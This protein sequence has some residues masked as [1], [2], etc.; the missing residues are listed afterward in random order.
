MKFSIKKKLSAILLLSS[1]LSNV[2]ENSL[3]NALDDVDYDVADFS[4]EIY[5]AKALEDTEKQI[6]KTLDLDDINEDLDKALI[7]YQSDL[8]SRNLKT[9]GLA[10]AKLL[11]YSALT[12]CLGRSI[13]SYVP[14][15][16][17]ESEEKQAVIKDGVGKKQEL[18]EAKKLYKND[19]TLTWSEIK[20]NYQNALN[21]TIDNNCKLENELAFALR[22]QGQKGYLYQIQCPWAPLGLQ[23]PIYAREGENVKNGG[24][25]NL[26]KDDEKLVDIK[27]DV[28]KYFDKCMGKFY[29]SLTSIA[30]SADS[31]K[32]LGTL[33]KLLD[34]L[35]SKNFEKVPKALDP[36]LD[37]LE[38]LLPVL[39][40]FYS[41]SDS[42]KIEI[43]FNSVL[44]FSP[45][46]PVIRKENKNEILTTSDYYKSNLV[47]G[48]RKGTIEIDLTNNKIGKTWGMNLYNI[49]QK[50]AKIEC[51]SGLAKN[52]AKQWYTKKTAEAEDN[53]I[54]VFSALCGDL[55]G[56]ISS[57]RK[58]LEDN[59]NLISTLFQTWND[60]VLDEIDKGENY[61]TKLFNLNTGLKETLL[62]MFNKDEFKPKIDKA[63]QEEKTKNKKNELDEKEKEQ[64][65]NKVINDMKNG[66][67]IK[68]I[69]K[70]FLT[71]AIKKQLPDLP[72]FRE[73][74]EFFIDKFFDECGFEYEKK[75][76]AK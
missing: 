50:V 68:R 76:E 48:D 53:K 28:K 20:N 32:I 51:L 33:E 63:E 45:R 31:M 17:F 64:I 36:T 19:K 57:V 70:K 43:G 6:Y 12:W 34:E 26:P 25:Y 1:F 13:A 42:S 37:L 35:K 39:H 73:I 11:T 15:M 62:G 54:K 67:K 8:F 29:T 72:V 10:S 7:K 65:K 21:K 41:I 44:G 30:G 9:T 69:N 14:E 4:S 40:L 60:E 2:N 61:I 38:D 66:M 56:I 55:K 75:A 16:H 5:K 3:A 52:E 23:G 58:L 46:V 71:E 47:P 18:E 59:K 24:A 74:G 49:A 27:D 22:H